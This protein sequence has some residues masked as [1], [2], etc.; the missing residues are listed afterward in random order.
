MKSLALLSLIALAACGCNDT[1]E[2]CW[3]IG[4]PFRG[5]SLTEKDIR[6][7]RDGS[8]CTLRTDDFPQFPKCSADAGE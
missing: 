7:E 5:K 2:G 4:H 3:F 1:E 8:A 6:F